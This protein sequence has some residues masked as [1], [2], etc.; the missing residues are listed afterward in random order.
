MG[1]NISGCFLLANKLEVDRRAS[2]NITSR[3]G[4]NI[5][6][7]ASEQ[8][9]VEAINGVD[10]GIDSDRSKTIS[11]GTHRLD[12]EVSIYGRGHKDSHNWNCMDEC[13]LMHFARSNI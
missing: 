2:L 6:S 4:R 8:E 11:F 1:G 10:G 7:T 3:R 9:I 12:V 13:Y 5:S